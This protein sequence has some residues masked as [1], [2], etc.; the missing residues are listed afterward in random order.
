MKDVYSAWP[1]IVGATEGVEH[2]KPLAEYVGLDSLLCSYINSISSAL[3]LKSQYIG[4][5]GNNGIATIKQTVDVDQ[6]FVLAT[7]R[8]FVKDHRDVNADGELSFT[9]ALADWNM[10]T[11]ELNDGEMLDIDTDSSFVNQLLLKKSFAITARIYPD[12]DAF[13][14]MLP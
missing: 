2:S 10:I 12:I 13:G 7:G 1:I 11:K 8:K 5:V 9:K 4:E 14:G 6:F 3:G